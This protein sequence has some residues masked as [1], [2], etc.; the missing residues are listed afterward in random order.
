M[1]PFI[2]LV[3]K[4]GG[5]AKLEATF[6]GQQTPSATLPRLIGKLYIFVTAGSVCS[7]K[8]GEKLQQLG[9]MFVKSD[10]SNNYDTYDTSDNFDTADKSFGIFCIV[11]ACGVKAPKPSQ[12]SYWTRGI[13]NV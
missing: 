1:G 3:I 13:Q 7:G 9:N 2:L 5:G 11:F 4:L 12:S 8:T 10:T 6:P